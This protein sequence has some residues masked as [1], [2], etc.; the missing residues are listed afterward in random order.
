MIDY[1]LN[2]R[3]LCIAVVLPWPKLAHHGRCRGYRLPVS[4]YSH[5]CCGFLGMVNGVFDHHCLAAP[6]RKTGVGQ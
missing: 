1:R 6:Q 4:Q 2:G 3:P 5:F